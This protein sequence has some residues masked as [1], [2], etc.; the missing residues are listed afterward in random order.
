MVGEGD[1]LSKWGPLYLFSWFLGILAMLTKENTITLP[2]MIILCELCFFKTGRRI[3]WRYVLPFLVILPII[4]IL[5]FSTK[6]IISGDMGRLAASNAYL[7]P[8]Y[9][10]TQFRVMITY[11]RLLFIPVNQNL[12]Y[13]YPLAKAFFDPPSLASLIAL[14]FIVIAAFKLFKRY[15]L[16]SFSIFWFLITILPESSLIHLKEDFIYEHWLYLPLF[17]YGLFLVSALYYL[18]GKNFL[19]TMVSVLLVIAACYSILAYNRNLVWKDELTLWND[20]VLKSPQ[21]ARPYDSRG[22]AYAEKGNLD[23]AI[24]DFTRAINIDP[25][26]ADAYNNRG[27][28]YVRK[29]NL[30]QAISDCNKAIE[31]NPKYADAYSNRGIVYFIKKEYDKSWKD[32]HKAEELGYKVNPQFLAELKKVSGREK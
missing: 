3:K 15:R 6:S 7:D 8:H 20:T 31:I 18:F 13:D 2:L 29:G 11:I 17:G 1:P 9:F 19:K 4:P 30:D 5:L 26:G 28:A 27:G 32:V 23:Q 21:K 24:S 16:I 14:I 22:I 12:D 25:R 10:L